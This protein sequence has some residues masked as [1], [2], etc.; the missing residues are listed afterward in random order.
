[1]KDYEQQI[2]GLGDR[3]LD[4][5]QITVALNLDKFPKEVVVHI[6]AYY[7]PNAF[8]NLITRKLSRKEFPSMTS[9]APQAEGMVDKA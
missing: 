9:K 8:G 7:R 4:P 5:S 6:L 2:V 3:G 1:M